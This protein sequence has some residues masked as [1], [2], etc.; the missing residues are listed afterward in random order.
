MP[1]VTIKSPLVKAFIVISISVFTASFFG[2]FYF[3]N[4][5]GVKSTIATVSIVA[6]LVSMVPVI[7]SLFMIGMRNPERANAFGRWLDANRI[8]FVFVFLPLLFISI[9]YAV[10]FFEGPS[11]R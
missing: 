5:Y 7:C 11:M 3:G 10:R 8:I 4:K 2:I 6:A 9:S 1:V